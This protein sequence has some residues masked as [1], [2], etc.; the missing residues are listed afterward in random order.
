LKTSSELIHATLFTMIRRFVTRLVFVWLCVQTLEIP[1]FS[2]TLSV[3]LSAEPTQFDPLLLEDGQALKIAA[4]TFGTLFEYDGKG[5]RSKSLVETYGVS[6]DRKLYTFKFRKGLVWSDGKPFHASHFLLA[7]KRLVQSPIRAALSELFPEI[8]LAGC[9]VVDAKTA[10]IRLKKADNQFLNWLTLPPFAPIREDLIDRYT[11]GR[12]PVAPTLGAYEITEYK[13]ESHLLLK[14]NPRFHAFRP[15]TIEEV[16][17]RF[18]P[19]EASLLPLFK[20][21]AVDILNKVPVLQVEDIAEIGTVRDVAVEAVTYLAFNTR[22]PPFNELKN[23]LAVRDALAG[24]KKVEL[25]RLLKT[26]ELAAPTFLPSILIPSGSVRRERLPSGNKEKSELSLPWVIQSDMSSRNKTMLEY[27]QSEIKDELG[28]R[29]TLDLVDWKAHYARL[30][31]EPGQMFRFG[32][33]N[34]VSDPYVVYQVLTSKS[35][36]NFTGWS[37]AEFD[38]L[39][40]DLR[41]EMRQVKKS[42]LISDIELIL[43]EEAPVVPLLHQRLKFAYSKRVSG[44]RANPFGIVVFRELRLTEEK[45]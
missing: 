38:E 17:I 41:Q 24:S 42:K 22:K 31:T 27:V 26:G 37:N 21:G 1:A 19:E 32:W 4:N 44:F 35:P 8:D 45:Q 34:P 29:P 36:N 7:V 33:Q 10:E 3:Q 14:R 15:E 43:W 39:V 23:R 20:S 5:E 16:K 12:N 18:L 6:R 11:K 25:A 28:W 30:K 2:A 13:R 40:E 9:R